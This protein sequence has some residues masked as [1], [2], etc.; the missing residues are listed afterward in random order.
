MD[1]V[2]L[3]DVDPAAHAYPAV[4]FP[5]QAGV[6]KPPEA[7]YRPALHSPEQ[8]GLLKPLEAPYWP[9]AQGVQ[10][11]EDS[12]LNCPAG[13]SCVVALVDPGGQAYPGAQGPVQAAEPMP[14]VA[15]YR[16]AAQSVHV[17]APAREYLPAGHRLAVALVDPA[18]QACPATQL[19][20]QAAVDRPVVAP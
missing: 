18:G 3:G 20:E 4:Q 10:V 15:P 5:V 12:G 13:H 14:P 17:A 2:A 1:A 6:V 19:P 8:K 7:P 11:P 16:P 9:M